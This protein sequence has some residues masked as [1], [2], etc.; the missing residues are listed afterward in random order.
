MW[1]V[2]LHR[3]TVLRFGWMSLGGAGLAV[4]AGLGIGPAAAQTPATKTFENAQF[5]YSVALPAGCRHEEGPGT[6]DAVCSPELDAEKSAEASAAA[7]LLLEVDA[8]A[9]PDDAGK[10]PADL[11]Q[12]YSEANFKDELPEAVCGEADK[13]RVKI[14]N[15]KQVLQEARVVY[16]ADVGCPEIKFLGLGERGG[17]AQ[18]LITPGLRY[19]LMA[20][21]LKEDFEQNKASIDAFFTSFR[22]LPADTKN[23]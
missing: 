11:A 14:G 21:A 12:R 8:E 2:M 22:T 18:F 16:T 19:R 15:V 7:S 17:V 10:S 5:R 23:Q 20:R 6:L 9:V 13:S 3:L 4:L 1:D